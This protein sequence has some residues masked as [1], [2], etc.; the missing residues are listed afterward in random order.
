MKGSE[1]GGEVSFV[2]RSSFSFFVSNRL[3]KERGLT[4]V[5][6]SK[7]LPPRIL[8]HEPVVVV[9]LGLELNRLAQPIDSLLLKLGSLERLSNGLVNR[10]EESI[11]LLAERA[12]C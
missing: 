10:R 7:L 1:G 2:P 8:S 12:G 9:A 5:K 4:L 3:N 6:S 11:V